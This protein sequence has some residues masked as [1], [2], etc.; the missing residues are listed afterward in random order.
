[1]HPI[2]LTKPQKV[3]IIGGGKA[4]FTKLKTVTKHH[5]DITC[6]AKSFLK[7]FNEFDVKLET[8]DFYEL[9][10]S[11]FDAFGMIYLSHDYPS[12][13]K[14]EDFFNKVV[15]YLDKTNK[16]FSVSSKPELGNFIS[17]ATRKYENIIVS[18]STSGESPKKAVELAE[19]LLNHI[20]NK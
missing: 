4:A 16:L 17:P 2:I 20:K 12:T 14:L 1:M 9:P 18:V 8:G 15:E 19:D 5:Q 11:Y 6:L 7:Q 10:L 3:L 13:S